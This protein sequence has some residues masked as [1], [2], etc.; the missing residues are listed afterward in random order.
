[1]DWDQLD[2]N[3]KVTAAIKRA[4]IRSLKEILNFSGP[5]IQRLTRLTI[6]DIQHL[7]KTVA[8]AVC[9]RPVITALHIYQ[10]TCPFPTQN[11]R[12]SLGCPVLN[13]FLKGGIPL[14]GV[15]ELSGESAAGKTQLSMQL[16]LSVQYPCKYGGLEGGAVYV[17]TE[18]AFPNKRLQQLISQQHKLRS[19]VPSNVLKKINFGDS[20]FI[21]HA[22]DVEALD[23]CIAKRIP[24]LLLRGLVRLVVIDSIAALFRCEF[25][26]KSSFAKA[27]H[28]QKFGGALV[29]LSNRY[30]VP[31]LCINQVTDAID[32][33]DSAQNNFGLLDKKVMPSLGM[34]WSNQLLMRLMISRT[35]FK[36]QDKFP[37]AVDQTLQSGSILRIIEVVF[38]PHLPQ[39]FCYYT[40]E[41]EGVRGW[42]V[43]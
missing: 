3:R 13:S 28:L 37:K 42:K 23:E 17:C 30:V 38:A 43:D 29:S 33:S 6:T 41:Q 16:C 5:D 15:T 18:D 31:I 24:I 26:A 27:K 32:P 12:L 1:M 2:L 25:E 40:V 19:D 39:S 34:V 11:Q 9:Q 10:G 14:M 7:Q 20:I 36:L 4:K 21:E 8:A 22:A 35:P